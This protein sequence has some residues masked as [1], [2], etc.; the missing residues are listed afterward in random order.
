MNFV[1]FAVGAE[2][3]AQAELVAQALRLTNPD[4][5]AW[6]ITDQ[7]TQF[8]TLRPYRVHSSPP[9][10]IFDRTV[11][12]NRFL[13][14]HGAALFLDSDCVVNT[15]IDGVFDGPVA[16]T[17]RV[18]PPN[19]PDQIYNGGV[20]YGDASD[21][22]IQFWTSWVDSM[23]MLPREAW[24]WFGDQLVL[25][26]LVEFYSDRV[27]VYECES[28]NYT[29]SELFEVQAYMYGRF[30]VHFKGRKRKRYL[31]RYVEVLKDHYGTEN[32]QR[33]DERNIPVHGHSELR[34]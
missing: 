10:L 27:N 16:V 14:E 26:S 19:C 3:A 17:E 15:A 28:H 8:E 18:P 23:L 21:A 32:L 2:C 6:C 24:K 25:P 5:T 4:A 7:E 12:Q 33:P 1:Y 20:L 13:R 22:C 31:E 11:G 34:L 29:P 30:I 9:T